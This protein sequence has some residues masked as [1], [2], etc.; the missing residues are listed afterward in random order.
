M[1][2]EVSSFEVSAEHDFSGLFLFFKVENILAVRVF[3]VVSKAYALFS[4]WLKPVFYH[5][6]S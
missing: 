4:R 3:L 2:F 5:G 1:V 6:F